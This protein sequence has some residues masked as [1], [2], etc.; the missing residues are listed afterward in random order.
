M[1][2]AVETAAPDAGPLDA[3][4]AA[5]DA[6]ADMIGGRREYSQQ[7]YAVIDAN[8]DLRERELIKMATLAVALADAL[9][10]RGITDPQAALAAEAGVGVFRVGFE[11][12]LTEPV[13]RDL[14]AVLREALGELRALL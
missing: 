4:A 3:V 7:R 14:A 12:W 13:D 5:L 8:A 1:V 10:G 2:A 9:R 11:R 6:A